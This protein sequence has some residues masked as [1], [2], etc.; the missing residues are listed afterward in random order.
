M[1]YIIVF[2]HALECVLL[3]NTKECFYFLTFA[4]NEEIID[5]NQS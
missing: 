4:N 5:T 2:L 3:G 1:L